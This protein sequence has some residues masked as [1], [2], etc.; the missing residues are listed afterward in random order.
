MYPL[1]MGRF[2]G[3]LK[4]LIFPEVG[5]SGFKAP[6]RAALTLRESEEESCL[7]RLRCD[8]PQLRSDIKRLLTDE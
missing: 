7:W 5:V 8:D 4:I 1:L 2:L 6:E 3:D